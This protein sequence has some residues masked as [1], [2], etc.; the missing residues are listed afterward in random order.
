MTTKSKIHAGQCK[1]SLNNEVKANRLNKKM[2]ITGVSGLLG[3][4]LALY[5]RNNYDILGLYLNHSIMIEGIKIQKADLLSKTLIKE[6]M[7]DF[8]PAVVIHCAAITDVDFC[9]TNKEL[10]D[11]I[12]IL[13]TRTVVEGM[14]RNNTKLIYISSDSVYEGNKGSYSE[15]DEIN[16]QNYYGISK[17][18]AEL[19]TSRREN[20]L[21]FRT[22]IFGWNIQN[23]KSL[24]EWII[25]ELQAKRRINGFND[26][27]F[28]SIYTF[29]FASIIDMA[30][31]RDL[32]GIYNCG[33]D[34]SISKYEFAI[35][36]ASYF[37]FDRKLIEPISIDD[38]NLKAKR[39]KNLSLVVD[40]LKEAL[41]YQIPSI[42]ESI[43]AFHRDFETMNSYKSRVN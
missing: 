42:E 20:S 39:G 2:L 14:N 25:Q 13:G 9:E 1:M 17:Y 11:R 10:T 41:T 26:V 3:S 7:Q 34:N 31:D 28:S 16:P 30:I 23:K 24:A 29:I 37:G 18:Q 27:Y 5:F 33:S 21:I 8:N 4:N 19:E 36:I 32:T 40:K 22:N 43:G 12:N 38:F 35:D 6:V 15:T